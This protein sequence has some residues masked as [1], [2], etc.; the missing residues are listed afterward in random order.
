MGLV[1]VRLLGYLAVN[2]VSPVRYPSEKAARQ[3]VGLYSSLVLTAP[4]VPLQLIPFLSY[5]TGQRFSSMA[6]LFIVRLCWILEVFS[7]RGPV[8][9]RF[10]HHSLRHVDMEV[11]IVMLG[12]LVL[13]CDAKDGNAP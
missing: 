7:H 1:S 4:G 3:I 11:V 6:V 13:S 8:D 5:P 2:Q 10:D 12:E 9:S